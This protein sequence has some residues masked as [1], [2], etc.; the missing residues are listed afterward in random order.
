M[1]L[2]RVNKQILCGLEIPSF[3]LKK[4]EMAV[5]QLPHDPFYYPRKHEM[6][7]MLTGKTP[8]EGVEILSPFKY[9]EYIWE[10]GL[11]YRFFPLTVGRYLEKN[12]NSNSPFSK[13]IYETPWITPKTKINTLAGTPRRQLSVYA[14]LSWTN[15][16][17]FDL[18]GVD[19]TGAENIYNTVKT[20]VEAG[21]AAIFIDIN[22]DF[23]ND[24]KVFIRPQYIETP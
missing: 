16:I 24:C 23:K 6:V 3:K 10:R 11:R 17:I 2:L 22:D 18:P 7:N 15:Q 9:A 19:P 14:A 4:G 1:L 21:G 5:I 8:G 13:K 20:V 12:A